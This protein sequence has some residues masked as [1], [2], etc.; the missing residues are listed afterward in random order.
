VPLL[1]LGM[2]TV[3]VMPLGTGLTPGD[4][5]GARPLGA[6][7]APR[8]PSEEVVPSEGIVVPT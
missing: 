8:V 3:P 7:D 6:M 5:P 1:V 2:V 4:V